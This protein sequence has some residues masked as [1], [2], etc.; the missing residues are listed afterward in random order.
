MLKS[1]TM[2]RVPR[3]APPQPKIRTRRD[4]EE[5]KR[6]ILDAAER[7]FA[8]HGP[9]AV[10]LADV[11]REAGVSHALV[12]HY[13]G[14]YDGLVDATLER[15]ALHVRSSVFAELADETAP[16][17]PGAL[18]DRLW[19]W[20]SDPVTLRLAAWA[21]LTNRKAD[22]FFPARVKG[23]RAVA[24]ALETRLPAAKGRRDDLEFVIGAAVS[25]AFGYALMR[26]AI[27]VSLGKRPGDALDKVFRAKVV[28]LLVGYLARR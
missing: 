6:L 5:A 8:A 21:S 13:F 9:D 15:R 20:V 11:A 22:D 4:P 24:D 28:E 3:S 18:L 16:P 26:P 2:S 14:T 27:A 23:L 17:D 19:A 10:G 25:L 7:V 1:A 12:S